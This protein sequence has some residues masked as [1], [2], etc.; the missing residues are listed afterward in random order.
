MG[1][2]IIKYKQSK[3]EGREIQNRERNEGE[4]TKNIVW[5]EREHSRTKKNVTGGYFEF[6]ALLLALILEGEGEVEREI[7][8][9]VVVA[10]E[11]TFSTVGAREERTF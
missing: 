6:R 3:G 11:R 7:T 10:M 1:G 2:R 9:V 8:V 4:E 5:G